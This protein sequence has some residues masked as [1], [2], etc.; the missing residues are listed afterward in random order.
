MA[1]Q[2]DL[3]SAARRMAT[4]VAEV[5]DDRLDAPTP[6]T[7]YTVGDLL[8]H[9]GALAVAFTKAAQEAARRG[10]Q[11]APRRRFEAQ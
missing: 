11:P 8:D 5:P 2:L 4:V 6:C 1:E 3:T 7:H 9:V 10:R